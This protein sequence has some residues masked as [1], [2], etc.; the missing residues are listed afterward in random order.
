MGTEPSVH[1]VSLQ[2]LPAL[3]LQH[4]PVCLRAVLAPLLWLRR[5]PT[6]S[7]VHCSA[8]SRAAQRLASSS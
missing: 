2:Q 1:G 7:P 5:W 8:L 6:P 3:I 4:L